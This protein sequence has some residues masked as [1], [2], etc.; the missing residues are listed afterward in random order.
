MK[1]SQCHFIIEIDQVFD[2]CDDFNCEFKNF[3]NYNQL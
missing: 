3:K 2:W 1:I